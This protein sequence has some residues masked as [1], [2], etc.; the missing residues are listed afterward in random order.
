MWADP[1][2]GPAGIS[3]SRIYVSSVATPDPVNVS[4]PAL[5]DIFLYPGSGDVFRYNNTTWVY[6]GNIRGPQ[7]IQGPIG[8]T[9]A[10]GI[11]G[12]QGVKGDKGDTG[13]QGPI[14]PSGGPV[15]PTGP[16]G[17]TGSPGTPGSVLFSGTDQ[18]TASGM[19]NG[20]YYFRTDNGNVYKYVSGAWSLQ[21]NIKGP[22]GTQGIQGNT[23]A[24]GAQGIQGLQGNTGAQG[25]AGADGAPAAFGTAVGQKRYGF[26]TADT[27]RASVTA[28]AVDSDFTLAVVSGATYRV[29]LVCRITTG[30][31]GMNIN[32]VTPAGSGSMS[33][34]SLDTNAAFNTAIPL[35]TTAVTLNSYKYI[36]YFTATFGGNFQINW[37]QNSSNATNS[38]MLAGSYLTLERIA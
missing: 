30:A 36:G 31:G 2:L 16:T 28:L 13:N 20:D 11:Q 8:N 32:A 14:G 26:K 25:P 29:E 9:G 24:T 38:T 21:A 17:A 27:S 23:G 19:V 37:A 12:I 5:G 35:T 3:G 18:T 1:Q 15:G 33:K 10:Q 34:T 6:V 22:Q 7:G 4:S